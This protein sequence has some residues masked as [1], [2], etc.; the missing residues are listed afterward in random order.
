MAKG[1]NFEV[2]VSGYGSS[3]EEWRRA[4]RAASSELP[5]LSEAQKDVARKFGVTEEEYKRSVL[6]LRYGEERTRK[7][8][9]ALGL[10]IEELL[11]Q[12]GD[13]YR[14]LA[15]VA[16]MGKERWV[17]RVQ[18]PAKTVNIAIDRDL[19]DDIIDSDTV[20]DRRRLGALLSE[21]L[22]EGESPTRQ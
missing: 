11:Q 4:Q 15:V 6:S 21:S 16:E 14:L 12:I 22:R 8:A 5:E 17:A 1:D 20:Q 7:R 10:I 19:G 3:V 9:K 2:L 13:A 18:A